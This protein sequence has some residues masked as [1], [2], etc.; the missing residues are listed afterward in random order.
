MRIP[1]ILILEVQEGSYSDVVELLLHKALRIGYDGLKGSWE[2]L[3]PLGVSVPRS[4]H[5]IGGNDRKDSGHSLGPRS[6]YHF[7]SVTQRWNLQR[8]NHSHFMTRFELF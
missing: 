7:S 8:V 6:G 3:G 5:R 4:H 1:K 2:G